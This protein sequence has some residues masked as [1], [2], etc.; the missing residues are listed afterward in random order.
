MRVVF[1]WWI[2]WAICLSIF[3]SCLKAC[4]FFSDKLDNYEFRDVEGTGKP[5]RLFDVK[6]FERFFPNAVSDGAEDRSFYFLLPLTCESDVREFFLSRY[7]VKLGKIKGNA[8]LNGTRGDDSFVI[9]FQG[10]KLLRVSIVL[11]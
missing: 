2:V 10:S 9:L 6:E 4:N 7:S 11:K 8:T 1:R 3:F 5:L